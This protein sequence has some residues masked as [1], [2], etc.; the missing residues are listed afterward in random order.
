[1]EEVVVHGVEILRLARGD[2]NEEKEGQSRCVLWRVL[3]NGGVGGGAVRRASKAGQGAAGA[4]FPI[5]AKEKG[6]GEGN[7]S[8]LGCERRPLLLSRD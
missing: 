8:A 7:S 6:K 5:E 3:C 1:M 4:L 2:R